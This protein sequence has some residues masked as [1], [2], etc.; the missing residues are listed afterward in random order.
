MAEAKAE[1]KLYKPADGIVYVIYSSNGQLND[2]C[3]SVDSIMAFCDK[4]HI[5]YKNCKEYVADKISYF[6]RY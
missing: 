2:S 5:S 6:G 1:I 4:N 3:G